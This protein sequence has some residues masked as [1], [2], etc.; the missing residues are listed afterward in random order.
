MFT[1]VLRNR[2][3]APTMVSRLY[4]SLLSGFLQI[5]F[6]SP[7]HQCRFDSFSVSLSLF[8]ANEGN[9]ACG[10]VVA[11]FATAALYTVRPSPMPHISFRLRC[12]SRSARRS[13]QCA[14]YCKDCIHAQYSRHRQ[15]HA[16]VE[17]STAYV[18]QPSAT[19]SCAQPCAPHFLFSLPFVRR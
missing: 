17:F 2:V 15:V 5:S 9:M 6:F 4:L 8:L 14:P 11:V 18:W 1:R 16:L 10:S 13:L 7:P 12:F 19:C 3:M